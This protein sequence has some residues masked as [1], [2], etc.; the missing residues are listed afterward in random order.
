MQKSMYN[1]ADSV[2]LISS[3]SGGAVGS[4]FYLNL[5]H[6]DRRESFD[7]EAL[8]HLT[9]VVSESSL[10][11]IAWALVYRDIPRIFFPYVNRSSEEKLFDRGFMLEESWRNRGNIQ[12]NLSN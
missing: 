8:K 10:D 11:D 9:E 5:F 1:F 2:T 7:Q 6:P 12:A 4:M 3:V